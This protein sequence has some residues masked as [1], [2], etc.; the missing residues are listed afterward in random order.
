MLNGP[1]PS[2]P[3]KNLAFYLIKKIPSQQC[4]AILTNNNNDVHKG[5]SDYVDPF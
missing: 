3:L 2:K 1:N 4:K 5:I